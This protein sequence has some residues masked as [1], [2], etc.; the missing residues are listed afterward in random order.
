MKLNNRVKLFL[1]LILLVSFMLPAIG[2]MDSGF[3]NKAEAKN[4]V[5]NGVKEGKWVE[6]SP[7]YVGYYTLTIYKAGK[8]LGIVRQYYPDGKLYLQS[9]YHNGKK[10]GLE[11][12]YNESGQL[13][14]ETLF[15]N[16]LRNGI[17]KCYF[18]SANYKATVY[19]DGRTEEMGPQDSL[20]GKLIIETPWVNGKINGVQKQ[21][22]SNG[23]VQFE[24]PY[25]NNIPG[26]TR[27]Y[28]RNGNEIKK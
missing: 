19:I 8:P 9:I 3:T 25:A 26:P 20:D 12:T 10:N 28:D 24:T 18:A 11:K 1:I 21:Y 5:V 6:N 23:K 22:Y 2:Q 17:E 27:G 4:Q 16:D 15:V 13:E 7:I 14:V